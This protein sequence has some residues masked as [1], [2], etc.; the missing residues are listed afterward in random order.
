MV[1]VKLNLA[2][3]RR[4]IADACA[5]VRRNPDDIRLVAVSKFQPPELIR[6][7]FE[8]GH[9]DFGENYGQELRDK[10]MTLRDLEGLVWHATGPLQS[11]KV[12]YVA[13][14]ASAFHAL[15]NG[16]IAEVMGRYRAES[17][18]DCYIEVN[19]A[20]EPTKS[21]VSPAAIG[22]LLSAVQPMKGLRIVGLMCM[23]PIPLPP[24]RYDPALSRPYFQRLRSLADEFGLRGLSMGTTDD[25]EIAIEEGATIV[26]VGRSIFGT[27]HARL[28]G[29]PFEH[30]AAHMDAD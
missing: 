22:D 17:P 12:K 5:R 9:R 15:D 21:G 29:T 14:A 25:F 23:P 28:K 7:A 11:N 1:D 16:R 2:A 20:N 18:I 19:I 27:R 10:A 6:Q 4:R 26:R 30:L 8:A 13:R 3:V 24:A